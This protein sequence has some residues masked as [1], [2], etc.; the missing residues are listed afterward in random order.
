MTAFGA[1]II[2]ATLLSF[3]SR[4]FDPLIVGGVLGLATLGVYSMAQ[5]V[6]QISLQVINKSTTDVAFSALSRLSDS[7]ERRR[8]AF[9][10][11]IELTAVLCFPVYVGLALVAKPLTVTLFGADWADS[12]PVLELFALS[13]VPFSLSL[14]HLATIKS[15]AKTRYLFWINLT[16]LLVYLPLM[17]LLV[18]HGPAPA[19]AASLITSVIILPVEIGLL[20]AALSLDVAEYVKSLL[21]GAIATAVMAAI[22]FGVVMVESASWHPLLQLGVT[23]SVGAAVYV[24]ALRVLA[25]VTFKR[26]LE[27]ALSTIRKTPPV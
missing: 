1:P 10:R 9:Y 14:V 11:V 7:E 4:R 26:C 22:T 5:R 17:T 12:A 2:G 3:V 8:R 27:L 16:L 13:G 20:R 15:A 19:A 21:G 24:I 25:P 6:F 23:I 18:H